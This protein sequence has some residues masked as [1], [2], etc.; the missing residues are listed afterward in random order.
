MATMMQI[1]YQIMDGILITQLKIITQLKKLTLS[2]KTYN[3]I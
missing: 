2:T 1:N 3:H